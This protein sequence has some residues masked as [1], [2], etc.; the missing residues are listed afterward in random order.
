MKVTGASIIIKKLIKEKVEYIFGYPGGSVI[1]LFDEL[2]NF[3]DKIKLIQPRHEQG[4]THAADGYARSTG[5]TGVIVVTSGPGAT[6]TVTGI[7]TAYMDSVPLVIITGQ[8]PVSMMGSDAF[9]EVDTTAI[10]LPI[11]KANFLIKDIKELAPSLDLA[12]HIAKS[13]RP[14]PVLVDIPSDIQKAVIEEAEIKKG[15]IDSFSNKQKADDKKINEV[16]KMLSESKKPLIISGGGI[17]I[18]EATELLKKFIE[19]NNI[20]VITT[21]MGKGLYPAKSE[22]YFDG[23]GMHGTYYGN[24]AVQNSDLILALG[25]R[26]SDRILGNVEKF[27]PNAKIVHVDIDRSEIE[28]NIQP[29]LGIEGDV[30]AV[31]EKFLSFPELKTDFSDWIKELNKQKRDFPL[32]YEKGKK[33]KPQYLIELANKYFPED[34]VVVSDVGQNQMWTA[35]FYKFKKPRT[36][37]TTGG[38]GTM[39][40]GLPAAMGAK[41]GKPDK[42]VLVISGDGGFQMN[43]QELMTIKRYA[44]NVKILIVDNAYLGMVKQWQELFYNKRYSAT[45]FT[46]NPDFGAI[47]KVIG[48]K[49]KTLK[50][51]DKAE[52]II[53]ELALSKESMLIHALIDP[54]ENVFPMVP[55]GASLNEILLNEEG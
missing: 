17:I 38:L 42:E 6:N 2:Y 29:I 52:E 45:P 21:L 15:D 9:Q 39:G 54:D 4:G 36:F 43:I 18:S 16:F 7:A 46:D 19:K 41:V 10:T 28:K 49:S 26:F 53:K 30:R 1:P 31:L 22:L 51:W 44:L 3:T 47:A 14:G 20:P 32:V 50:D 8:V 33:L 12:F 5:K 25:V 23:L 40:F 27:A 37:L 48:I 11:T 24:Y 35:Q 13:G 34:T 55:A